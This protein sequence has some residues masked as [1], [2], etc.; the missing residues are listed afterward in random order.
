MSNKEVRDYSEKLRQGLVLAEQRML[1]EKALHGEDLIV[2]SDGK[3]IQRIP[4][5]DLIGELNL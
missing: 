1:Q 5:K 2:S 3:I 4:A